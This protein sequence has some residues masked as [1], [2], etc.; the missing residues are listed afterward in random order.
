MSRGHH[1]ALQLIV[2]FY[3]LFNLALRFYD[4]NKLHSLLKN[5]SRD[6]NFYP[7]FILWYSHDFI[8]FFLVDVLYLKL[9]LICHRGAPSKV[10]GAPPPI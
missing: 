3:S 2:F 6:L 9:G 8:A 4:G 10:N 1:L 7:F 5:D